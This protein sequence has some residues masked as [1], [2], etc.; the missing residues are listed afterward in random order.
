LQHLARPLVGSALFLARAQP[1]R[2]LYHL[3]VFAGRGLGWLD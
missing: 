2:S 1:D 3:R